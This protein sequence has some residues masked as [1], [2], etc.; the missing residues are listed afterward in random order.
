MNPVFVDTVNFIKEQFS[1]EETI[2]LHRPVFG[3]NEKKY[4]EECI[5]TTFVSSVGKFVTLFEERIKEFTGAKYAVATV[6]GTAALHVALMMAGVKRDDL[7]ITQPLTFIATCNAISYLSASPLF[8]DIDTKTLGLSDDKLA[9]FLSSESYIGKDGYCYHKNSGKRIAACVPMH[10]FG[11]PVQIDSIKKICDHY[12]IILI[13]DAAESIG[14]Y[15]RQQH[16]GT[17]GLIGAFSFNGNKTITCGGGGVV[18]TNDESIALKAKHITTQAKVPH[19]WDFVHDS[20]GYN[21]RMPNINAA[22]ACAQLEQIDGFIENKRELAQLYHS[23][24]NSKGITF[25][26]EPEHARS[27]YWLNAILLEN[28]A[29][30]NAF[31]QYTN[32]NGIMTRPVWELMNRLP[33]FQ[34]CFSGN[35][36]N[37]VFIADRLVNIPSSVRIKKYA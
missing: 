18:I 33:M 35:L 2:S 28:R 14:T 6:N 1:S 25:I 9:S 7:V 3:G 10:T 20:I 12:N 11:H 8:V 34:E 24:F 16:T 29:E 23:F 27:N 4:T 19:K 32:D 31:L 13:E 21:Y 15:Y 22:L 37:A 17:N 26:L 5:N 36:E 30:R